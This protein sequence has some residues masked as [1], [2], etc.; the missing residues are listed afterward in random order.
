MKLIGPY[1]DYI[2][3]FNNGRAT[4]KAEGVTGWMD[5]DGYLDP[6]FLYTIAN[7]GIAI[8]KRDKAAA[9]KKYERILEI[10]PEYPPA[11]NNLALL[12]IANKDY[13]KGM[14]KL[15]IAHELAPEDSVISKNLEWAKESRKE[16]RNERWQAGFEIATAIIGIAATT[17]TA[18]SSIKGNSVSS[19]SSSYV[20]GSSASSGSSGS[21]GGKS[22][23][24]KLACKTCG[25]T[26]H[27]HSKS[28]TANKYYCGGSGTCRYCSGGIVY[29]GG[30]RVTCT[31]CNGRNVCKY[32]KGTGKCKSCGGTGKG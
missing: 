27:C 20:G 5:T 15:K 31:A 13:N 21:S 32:C 30:T 19:G 24:G 12:D 7:Q 6:D 11:Y 10:D 18:Y 14:R 16:R 25:G 28:S 26:G 8:E 2:S 23:S 22:S 3:P 29:A 9:R 17:Y 4:I 1:L